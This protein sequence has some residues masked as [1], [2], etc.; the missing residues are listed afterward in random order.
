MDSHYSQDSAEITR[1]KYISLAA[2]TDVSEEHSETIFGEVSLSAEKNI[3]VFLNFTEAEKSEALLSTRVEYV[4][5]MAFLPTQK[6]R[7][8]AGTHL[9]IPSSAPLPM[10]PTYG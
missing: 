5:K 3:V 2:A 8:S 9:S 6:V 10:M 4:R 1:L 7:G